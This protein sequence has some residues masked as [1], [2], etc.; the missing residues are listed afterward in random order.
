METHV[1]V[2]MQANQ[3][4]LQ[5]IIVAQQP[6]PQ[7]QVQLG[8]DLFVHQGQNLK[9]SVIIYASV[10][11]KDNLYVEAA[12]HVALQP[13]PLQQQQPKVRNFHGR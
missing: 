11:M 7:N 5:P 13:P 12:I 3:S 6:Q 2:Q 1:S 8:E 10:Q 9:M 4:V